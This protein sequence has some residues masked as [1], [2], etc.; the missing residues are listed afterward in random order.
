M[1]K[2]FLAADRHDADLG[3]PEAIS[4]VSGGSVQARWKGNRLSTAPADRAAAEDGVRMAYREAGL[5]PPSIVWHDGPVSLA[6]SWASASC[7]AGTNA[8]DTVIITPYR[9][10]VRRLEAL[11]DRCAALLRDRFGD[12]CSCAVSAAVRAAVI[13]DISSRCP[14]LLVWFRRLRW[15]VTNKRRPPGFA[16]AGWSQHELCWL[17]VTACLLQMIE[18]RAMTRLRGLRLVAENAGWIVP[19]SD[20]CWLS[21]RPDALSYDLWGRLHSSSGPAL[22][23]RDGWYLH[24][25]K[26]T[27]LPPWII[28]EPH[29]ITLRWIDAQIDPLIRRAMIDIFTPERFVGAGGADCLASDSTGTL[30]GRKWSYLG[31]VIDTW[32][33]VEFPT[34]GGGRSFH[35]VPAHLRTPKEALAWLFGPRPRGH[36]WPPRPEADLLHAS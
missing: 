25:W 23:Y 9:Q 1:R 27:R 34:R 7:R 5:A 19:H 8:S 35:C 20:V 6:T 29:R 24:A 2:A 31:S 36:S 26:G 21:D 14:S 16:V 13:D 30:W 22:R 3:I 11:D 28:D 32:T 4:G 17:G 10:A 12:D 15:S 33:A 18:A